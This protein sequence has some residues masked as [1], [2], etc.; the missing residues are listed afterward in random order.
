MILDRYDPIGLALSSNIKSRPTSSWVDNVRANYAEGLFV[1]SIMSD[2]FALERVWEDTLLPSMES[3]GI[4]APKMLPTDWLGTTHPQQVYGRQNYQNMAQS[5]FDQALALE[6]QSPGTFD[7]NVLSLMSLEAV[8]GRAKEIKLESLENLEDVTSR[9]DSVTA[10]F[11]GRLGAGIVEAAHDP[12]QVGLAFVGPGRSLLA[13]AAW[14]AVINGGIEAYRQPAVAE[15]YR[16]LGLEYTYEDYWKAIAY[17]AVGGALFAG[18]LKVGVPAAGRAVGA[19]YRAGERA[20][21]GRDV[22]MFTRALDQAEPDMFKALTMEQLRSIPSAYQAAGV[23]LGSEALAALDIVDAQLSVKESNPGLAQ[24][25]HAEI[26]SA[27]DAAVANNKIPDL[28]SAEPPVVIPRE[29]L[30]QS[31]ADNLDGFIYKFDPRELLVDAKTFQFKEGGDEFGVTDAYRFVTQW[32]RSLAGTITVYQFADG[33]MFIA[34]GH[35]RMGI[36][37]RIMAADPSQEISLYGILYREVDG[38]TPKEAMVR[39]A[40]TNIVQG[41][42]SVIDAAKIARM[43]PARFQ[44]M[45]GKTLS[46]VSAMV[47]DAN[48][49]MSLGDDAWGAIVNKVIKPEYGSIVGQ[50]LSDKPELQMAAIDIINKIKPD[51]ADQARLLVRQVRE[52]DYDVSVQESLFGDEMIVETLLKERMQILDKA[53][54]QLRQ[55]RAAFSNLVRNAETVEVEGNVLDRS[56][57]QRRLDADAEAIARVEILAN[58]KGPLSDALTAAARLYKDTGRPGTATD[59]FVGAIRR[60]VADGD[61]DGIDGGTSGRIVEDPTPR[62]RSEIESEPVL[63]GF[64]EP[65]GHGPVV[66]QRVDDMTRDM[67]GAEADAEVA[68]APTARPIIETEQSARAAVE[69]TAIVD[70]ETG[71]PVVLYHGTDKQ[72]DLFDLEAGEKFDGGFAGSRAIYFSA[73]EYY[74][75]AYGVSRSR[76]T[77]RPSRTIKAYVDVKNPFFVGRI[78]KVDEIPFGIEK[79]LQR[80]YIKPF[81]DRKGI[82]DDYKIS[83]AD[84]DLLRAEYKRISP[85]VSEKMREIT[86]GM[87]AMEMAN[88]M[89][90]GADSIDDFG[91]ATKINVTPELQTMRE[92]LPR[93]L[94]ELGYDGVIGRTSNIDKLQEFGEVVVFDTKQIHIFDQGEPTLPPQGS[95]GELKNL[96]DSGADLA[97]IDNHPAVLK[98]VED[99]ASRKQTID[100][101]NFGTDAWHEERTYIIDGQQVKGTENALPLWEKQADELAWKEQGLTPEPV[102][103]NR[104]ATIILGPPA[105]GKSTIANDLAVF[106]KSAILDAD[107]IKKAIPGFNGGIGS[108]AVHEESSAL[109]KLLQNAILDGGKNVIIPKVGHSASGIS[110]LI[111]LLKDRGYTVN[112]MDMFVS[113]T[114]AKLR[115]YGR[116]ISSGRFI[117]PAYLDQVGGLPSQTYKILKSEGVADGFAQIDNNG[118]FGSTKPVIDKSGDDFLSGSSLDLDARGGAVARAADGYGTEAVGQIP[119]QEEGGQLVVPGAERISDK[120]LAERKMTQAMRGGQAAMPEGGLFDDV[121]RAQQDLFADV[122]LD[123]EIPSGARLTGENVLEAET[124]T[125]RDL[126]RMLDEEDDF[127]DRL[128]KCAL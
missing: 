26:L 57:N 98:A 125:L 83:D 48:G 22:S 79:G 29:T 17:G 91:N 65:T 4:E 23:R 69:G 49:L 52:A 95:I 67:F 13:F 66:E 27:V 54:K 128:G 126:K 81:L 18:A 31:L 45:I 123:M 106:S 28:G 116:F 111:S 89:Y 61:F 96:I 44:G 124:M 6:R 99:M 60:A 14:Q 75:T 80:H 19:A 50:I 40:F 33:R 21:V 85:L 62:P 15:N 5:L 9:G 122:D 63:D 39:A 76:Q 100:A 105:A 115:M 88:A 3:A 127:I 104:Q 43:D 37:R 25:A 73:A 93:V 20:V 97:I 118:A 36:A 107:E 11:V 2:R 114:N 47:R 35:Q 1:S 77:G 86:G 34:D 120:A 55:D 59:Q 102:A 74:A 58:R 72:F 38:V 24:S 101:E 121:A 41:T 53:I 92:N 110:N 84:N 51:N 10:G 7:P 8:D 30:E 103:T 87:D 56:A 68:A 64:D 12:V 117:P 108:A 109:A 82:I 16:S 70:P 119:I 94:Q 71:Q 46:P 78:G 90:A 32:D 42:G 113:P 112:L